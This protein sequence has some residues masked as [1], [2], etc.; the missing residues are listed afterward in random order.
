MRLHQ[1]DAADDLFTFLTSA[2]G[3]SRLGA[4]EAKETAS[5]TMGQAVTHN[6]RTLELHA[7]SAGHSQ[8]AFL[9]T[10]DPRSGV[11][12]HPLS[13]PTDSKATDQ[14]SGLESRNL[15]LAAPSIGDDL[16]NFISAPEAASFNESPRQLNGSRH[17][18]EQ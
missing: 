16:A 18:S 6:R 1:S 8:T 4:S 12:S 3:R 17:S 14:S 9:N 2:V 13:S 10:F 7:P 15:D 5:Q 11:P